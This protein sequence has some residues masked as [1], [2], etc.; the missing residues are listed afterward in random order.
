LGDGH[1]SG[2]PHLG[3]IIASGGLGVGDGAQW[4]VVM[5]K[6]SAEGT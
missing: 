6:V 1:T 3:E 4:L 2:G 5:K